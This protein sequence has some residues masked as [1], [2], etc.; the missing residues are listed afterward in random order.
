MDLVLL[1]VHGL[2]V[3]DRLKAELDKYVQVEQLL[4]LNFID[5]LLDLPFL[6]LVDVVQDIVDCVFVDTEVGSIFESS[7]LFNLQSTNYSYD[8]ILTLLSSFHW[9][10]DVQFPSSDARFDIAFDL[11]QESLEQVAKVLALQQ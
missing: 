6:P 2:A 1:D 7:H 4:V 9:F 5:T 11:T 10:L 3:F 8:L